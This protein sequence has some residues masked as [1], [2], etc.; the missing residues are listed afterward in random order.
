MTPV[1]PI[2]YDRDSCMWGFHDHHQFQD[3]FR[4][5]LYLP[6]VWL[7]SPRHIPSTLEQASTAIL[8]L[9]TSIVVQNHC[10]MGLHRGFGVALVR[11]LK[12]SQPKRR[13]CRKGLQQCYQGKQFKQS[14]VRRPGACNHTH[15]Q[16]PRPSQRWKSG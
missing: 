6:F 14:A 1:E 4:E 2:F 12:S 5:T 13:A 16:A 15:I 3:Q 8:H 11:V 7:A 9:L 10:F